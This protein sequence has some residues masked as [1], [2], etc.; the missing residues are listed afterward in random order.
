MIVEGLVEGH[1]HNVTYSAKGTDVGEY[2][3]NITAKA[4]V[5]ITAGGAVVTDNYDITIENGKLTIQERGDTLT[6]YF[7]GKSFTYDGKPHALPVEATTNAPK[8]TTTFK[9]S[10]D[11]EYWTEDLSSLTATDAGTYPVQVRATSTDYPG[12]LGEGSATLIISP[13]VATVTAQSKAF[14]YNGTAQSWGEYDVEGLVGDDEI[15]AVVTGSVTF[16][17]EGTVSNTISSYK[18]TVGKP[19]NYE[20]TTSDGELTMANASVPITIT[21][22]SA[23]KTYDGTALTAPAVIKVTGEL[24]AGDTLV[25]SANGSATDVADTVSGNNPVAE[26]Y[27]VMHGEQDVTASYDITPIA[28]TLAI[29]KRP[30]TFAGRSETKDYTGF[31]IEISTVAVDGLVEGHTHNVVFSAKGTDVGG[32]Y[33]GAITSANKVAIKSGEA[34][35]T[36]NYD[37][38]VENGALTIQ[39]ASGELTVLLDGKEYTYDGRRHA[40]PLDASTNASS[41]ETTILYSKDG[42]NWTEDLSS[43]VATDVEDSCAIQVQ[44][45]NSNYTNTAT[46]SAPL[47]VKERTVT[48]TAESEEFTYDGAAHSNGGFVVNGLVGEDEVTDVVVEG[49]VTFPSDGSVPNRV[50]SYKLLSGKPGNYTIETVDGGLTVKNASVP[51]TI[52]AASAS[53][54]YDGTALTN[55][56][57]T[58]TSGE[59]IAGDAF[60][61]AADGSAVNVADTAEGNNPVASYRITHGGV[62]VTA[63]YVITIEDGV[64]AIEPAKVT[65]KADSASKVAGEDDPAFIGT[66]EGLVAEGDLGTV[67]YKRTNSDEAPGTYKGVIT[68]EYTANGNY[69][70]T[71]VA[72]DFTISEEPVERGVYRVTSGAD[73]TWTRGSGEAL[74]LKVERTVDPETAFAHFVG[75]EVDG[76]AVPQKGASGEANWTAESGSVIL[77]IQPAYLETLADGEHTVAALF[78]DGDPA[79]AKFAVAAKAAPAPDPDDGG[80]GSGGNGSNGGASSGS[81]KTTTA[82]ASAY[83][84]SASA[85]TGDSIGMAVLALGFVA[86]TALCLALVALRRRRN[87]K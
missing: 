85:K 82:K 21:A 53:K 72:G 34:D 65:I 47:T 41:G 86:L 75:I 15:S 80:N 60:E 19:G 62:D 28:G 70:V 12:K 29:T 78:D 46:A 67:S 71:V 44:A 37:V 69:D 74:D 81:D 16:P 63:S 38:K 32:P 56:A 1:T 50:S 5:A 42:E 35:V 20:V 24:F 2:S 66:V 77:E 49:S 45:T 52:T 13:K 11:G 14:T 61:G 3:G 30:V 26:G 68:A 6:V 84:Q 22:A 36:A 54:V 10:L 39:I 48:I 55:P 7:D 87:V 25:A 8:N 4:D 33:A 23:S 59:L 83:A 18:F 17:S 31:E 76:E 9:Y 43:L 58:V 79:T 57:V 73:G 64:L 51:I 27:K 40:L